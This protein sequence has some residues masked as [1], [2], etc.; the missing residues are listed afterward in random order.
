M[1]YRLRLANPEQWTRPSNYAAGDAHDMRIVRASSERAARL[2][3]SVN[4]GDEGRDAWLSPT[5]TVETISPA[6]ALECLA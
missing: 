5:T 2:V 1:I 3:A 4:A 6:G